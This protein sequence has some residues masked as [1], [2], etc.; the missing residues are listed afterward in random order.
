VRLALFPTCVVD[1]VTP[2]VGVSTVR[3]LRRAGH[4]VAVPDRATCCGQPAWN[5][6]Q[7]E[8]AAEVARTTLEAL[9]SQAVDAIVVPA[10]SCATM[11]RVFWRELFELAG[12]TGEIAAVQDVAAR[13]YELAEFL[14]E[15]GAPDMVEPDGTT[16]VYHRSCHMLREL[17]ITDQPES[18]LAEAGADLVPQPPERCCGFGG[19]FSVKLPEVS[20]AMAD[21]VLDTAVA[22]GASRM[23]GC[24]ASCLLHLRG[25]AERR[26]LD[27]EFRHL[28]TVLDDATDG[29]EQRRGR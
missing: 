18:L 21:D 28:A 22:T 23:I 16:T 14:H 3:L 9:R 8:A 20:T 15:H 17:R 10:G 5:S 2:E 26:G 27:F 19:T 13:T 4:E 29:S 24:D 25:R 1:A 6:G 11:I 7:A 12:T